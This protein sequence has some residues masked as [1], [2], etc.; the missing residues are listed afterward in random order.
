IHGDTAPDV[1]VAE[2]PADVRLLSRVCGPAERRGRLR[3]DAIAPIRAVLLP[4]TL[5]GVVAVEF[6]GDGSGA[7]GGVLEWRC[8]RDLW[9]HD[10]ILGYGSSG[11]LA[12]VKATSVDDLEV[13]AIIK[14]FEALKT[15]AAAWPETQR[16]KAAGKRVEWLKQR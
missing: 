14:R 2:Q 15:S 7:V 3:E 11:N 5:V 6:S 4:A 9:I 1:V 12:I 16:W 13:V 10:G 8:K